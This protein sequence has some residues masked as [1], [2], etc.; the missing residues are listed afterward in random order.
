MNTSRNYF[1]TVLVLAVL[2]LGGYGFYHYEVKK[3]AS[4]VNT[5]LSTLQ[6]LFVN[7]KCSEIV[8]E[9]TTF[10]EN[11]KD[12]VDIWNIKASCEYDLGKFADAKISF[13]KVM[14]LRPDSPTAKKYLGLMV[15]P[16]DLPAQSLS[17]KGL[18]L[19][20]YGDKLP[21]EFPRNLPLGQI[22]T[23]IKS[24]TEKRTLGHA[25]LSH[26]VFIYTSPDTKDK[27]DSLMETYFE[28]ANYT[29]TK[30]SLSNQNQTL[31]VAKKLTKEIVNVEIIN[32]KDAQ[33]MISIH[34]TVMVS[35][36]TP[37]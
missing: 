2:I 10:L 8:T 5:E 30:S 26:S 13:A 7:K 16:D 27:L 24:Y 4:I 17:S 1:Y 34:Y 31:F 29:I 6:K 21:A 32:Q 11:H 19:K 35:P 12:A 14:A 33:V 37:K 3:E 20:N 23:V 22:G 15:S 28:E 9:A 18:I 36:N 25:S